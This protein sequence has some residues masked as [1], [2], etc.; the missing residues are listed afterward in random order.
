[1]PTSTVG[2]SAAARRAS[3]SVALTASGLLSVTP[4]TPR[5]ATLRKVRRGTS[6]L[7]I[8]LLAVGSIRNGDHTYGNDRSQAPHSSP[9]R[10]NSVDTII[11]QADREF[12]V[13]ATKEVAR[14]HQL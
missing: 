7:S 4:A 9:S 8:T 1:M 12:G 6:L 10:G 2:R 11:R 13:G 14:T 5:A 3:A